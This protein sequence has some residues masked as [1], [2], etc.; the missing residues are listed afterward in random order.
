MFDNFH[1]G[2]GY[3][4]GQPPETLVN[5]TVVPMVMEVLQVR[6]FLKARC[7]HFQKCQR[8]ILKVSETQ[9]SL[10]ASYIL[11]FMW[12]DKRIFY[13]ETPQATTHV[14][15]YGLLSKIWSPKLKV[16]ILRQLPA[17]LPFCSGQTCKTKQQ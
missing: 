4:A 7:N 11:A 12:N 14:L 3:D 9:F 15:D 10:T 13:K 8:H 1:L 17:L 2:E 5:V 6:H 16:G